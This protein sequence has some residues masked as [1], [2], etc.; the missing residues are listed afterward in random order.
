MATIRLGRAIKKIS[1][2]KADGGGTLTLYK[3]KKSKKKKTN[4]ELRPLERA[5][6]HFN[7]ANLA[8]AKSLSAGHR[9]SSRKRKNGWL[10]DMG[11]NFFKAQR[12]GFKK[13]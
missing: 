2:I 12:K 1:I 11:K 3:G 8:S 6:R 9:K 7:D 5:I 4:K 10:R 13:L